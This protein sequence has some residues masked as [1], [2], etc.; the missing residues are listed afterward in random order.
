MGPIF[1]MQV[2]TNSYIPKTFWFVILS[3][4]FCWRQHFFDDV[5]KKIENYALHCKHDNQRPK[6]RKRLVDPPNESYYITLNNKWGLKV[7]SII[8]FWWRHHLFSDFPW[9]TTNDV[10]WRY[11]TPSRRNF[12]KTSGSLY[13]NV[14]VLWC[15]YKGICLIQ[16]KVMAI[17]VFSAQ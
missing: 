11:A 10:I 8:V 16:V 6:Y 13:L 5:N 17:S 3:A 12:L 15:E 4:N 1:G 2:D 7:Q 14:V 9:N